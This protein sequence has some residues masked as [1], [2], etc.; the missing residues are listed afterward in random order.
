MWWGLLVLGVGAFF[1]FLFGW[2][3]GCVS[4]EAAP[5][6]RGAAPAPPA[7][8]GARRARGLSRLPPG[9]CSRA[10]AGGA[11]GSPLHGTGRLR[12]GPACGRHLPLS[13][14]WGG[15]GRRRR[16]EASPPAPGVGGKRS[17]AAVCGEPGA[18]PRSS[19]P[20]AGPTP[21]LCP[22][23]EG[24]KPKPCFPVNFPSQAARGAHPRATREGEGSLGP[25][26]GPGPGA[27]GT[28]LASAP[29]ASE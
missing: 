2:S 18:R 10:A 19:G 5:C 20:R 6:L 17:G 21:A 11:E 14:G 8:S 16:R 23:L 1:F 13:T 7:A 25:P 12:P 22:Q 3:T 24:E 28:K 15:E 26:A 9:L 27:A 29:R 4:R